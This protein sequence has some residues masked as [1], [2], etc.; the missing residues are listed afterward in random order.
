[1]RSVEIICG[2]SFSINL[3][4]TLRQQY[5]ACHPLVTFEQTLQAG[6]RSA[7]GLRCDK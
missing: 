4:T 2:F 7:A 5:A 1:M 3:I 6:I